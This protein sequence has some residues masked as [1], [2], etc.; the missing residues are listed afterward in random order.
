MKYKIYY[1]ETATKDLIRLKRCEPSSFKKVKTLISE[2]SEHPST[3]TG[4]PERLKGD[5]NQ[6]WSRRINSKHR[7]VYKIEEDIVQVLVVS[8][9]GHY[10]NK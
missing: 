7:L 4:K 1:T 10:D 5:R 6:Q 8:A 9:Y 3:G 2:L